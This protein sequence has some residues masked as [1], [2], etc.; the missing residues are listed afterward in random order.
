MQEPIFTSDETND[1]QRALALAQ[2]E[3]LG[4]AL[5]HMTAEEADAGAEQEVGDY[6]IG[7][8]VE[9]AEGLYE[10]DGTRAVW[11]EPEAENA[12]IE[13]SV[14]SAADGRFLPGCRV[15]ATI[16]GEGFRETHEQQMLWHP[17][18]YHYGRNWVIPREGDYTLSIR[19]E[20]PLLMRHDKKNGNRYIEPAEVA[21]QGIRLP[22]GKKV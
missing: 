9:R 19:V 8:A 3:A 16:E 5:T 12:H 7:Y 6:R 4:R 21:F 18:L 15:Y 2:G 11:R 14:R 17:W 1:V 13:V 20:P 10:F 22:L